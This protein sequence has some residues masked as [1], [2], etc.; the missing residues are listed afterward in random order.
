MGNYRY[1][2]ADGYT[3]NKFINTIKI[4]AESKEKANKIAEDYKIANGW[5]RFDCVLDWEKNIQIYELM[6]FGKE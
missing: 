6:I 4:I 1:Y 5:T 2:K 3:N